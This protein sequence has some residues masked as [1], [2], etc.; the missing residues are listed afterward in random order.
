MIITETKIDESFPESQFVIQG[1]SKPY[2]LDRNSHGGGILIYVREDIPSKELNKRV[3]E[4]IEGIFIEVNF[5]KLW[6][7]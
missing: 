3:L 4:D 6:K 1:F 7:L 2:R 5:R